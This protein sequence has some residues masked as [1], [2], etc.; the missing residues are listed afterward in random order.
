MSVPEIEIKEPRLKVW[1]CKIGFALKHTL[2]TGADG[3]M[4]EAVETAFR[5]MLG[6]DPEFIFSGW[7]AELTNDEQEILDRVRE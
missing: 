2:P 3:P 4:R 7:G 5:D 6:Y 1:E